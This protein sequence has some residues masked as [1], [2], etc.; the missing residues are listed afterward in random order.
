MP[1]EWDGFAI[2]EEIKEFLKSAQTIC[3]FPDANHEVGIFHFGA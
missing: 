3:I 1:G 2:P